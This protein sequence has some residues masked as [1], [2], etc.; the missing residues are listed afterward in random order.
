MAITEDFDVSMA[1]YIQFTFKYG[2]QDEKTEW[3][4]DES[5]VLQYSTNG[6]MW[7]SLLKEVFYPV[8]SQPRHVLQ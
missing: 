4:K 7:W 6:G 8:D 2:C 1:T 3:Q 5:V